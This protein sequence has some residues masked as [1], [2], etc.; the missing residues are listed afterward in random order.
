MLVSQFG[1]LLIGQAGML[2]D[3]KVAEHFADRGEKCALHGDGWATRAVSVIDEAVEGTRVRDHSQSCLQE[4]RG[5]CSEYVTGVK[6]MGQRSSHQRKGRNS[7]S[8]LETEAL[9]WICQ[10]LGPTWVFGVGAAPCSPKSSTCSFGRY[11]VDFLG[12][13]VGGSSQ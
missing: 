13:V 8:V 4:A 12:V 11:V 6:M 10:V 1:H 9:V 3:L 5:A 2:V 7:V